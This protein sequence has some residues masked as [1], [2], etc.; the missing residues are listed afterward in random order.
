MGE[1]HVDIS[2][3]PGEAVSYANPGERLEA[4]PG[5]DR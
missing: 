5:A 4:F 3:R 2:H 1:A